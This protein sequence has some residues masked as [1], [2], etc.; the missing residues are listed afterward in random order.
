MLECMEKTVRLPPDPSQLPFDWICSVELKA[1]IIKNSSEIPDVEHT[2]PG[3][4][5]R[6]DNDIGLCKQQTNKRNIRMKKKKIT[7]TQKFT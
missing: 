4:G 6:F 2:V 1:C 7:T 3:T 5:Y